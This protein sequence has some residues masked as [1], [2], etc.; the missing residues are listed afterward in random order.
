MA[1]VVKDL[2]LIL[3][4]DTADLACRYG[5]HSGPVTAGVLRGEKSR[6]QVSFTD[7]MW[8]SNGTLG[9]TIGN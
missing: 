7:I 6:F 2:E 5:I 8:Y 9:A 1:T 4:P 3:G